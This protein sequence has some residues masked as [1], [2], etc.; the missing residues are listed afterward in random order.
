MDSNADEVRRRNL[1]LRAAYADLD[2]GVDLARRVHRMFLPAR[3]PALGS[4]RL[5]VYHRPRPR[6]GCVLYDAVTLGDRHLA[7]WVAAAGGPAVTAGWVGVAVKH[8]AAGPGSPA[9]VLGRVNRALL[10]LGI[11]PPSLVG[12]VY[13]L[14]DTRTGEVAVSRGGVPPPIRV[15][16]DGPADV[17]VGPGP[18]LGAF[19]ADFPM[20]SARL[21]PGEKL[22]LRTGTPVA[23]ADPVPPAAVRHRPLTGAVF[24]DAVARDVGMLSG[25]DEL[26]LVVVEMIGGG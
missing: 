16:A 5:A 1:E 22:I 17:W 19:D 10:D 20:H 13:A 21:W 9:E 2:R 11:D 26:T 12:M 7:V 18:F 6:A 24:A 14:I 15:P 8:A 4:V 25:E 3:L 23:D